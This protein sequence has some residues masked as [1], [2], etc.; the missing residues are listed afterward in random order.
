MRALVSRTDR[1]T[2]SSVS[3]IVLLDDAGRDP[4]ALVGD[5]DQGVDVVDQVHLRR[6]QDL[7]RLLPVVDVVARADV[8]EELALEPED[9]FAVF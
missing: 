4:A 8:A 3:T 9:R 6:A 5:L 2:G 7:L 1:A